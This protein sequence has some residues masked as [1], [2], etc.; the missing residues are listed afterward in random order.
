[1]ELQ[2][3]I[4]F[5]ENK[6]TVIY[7]ANLQGKTNVINAIRYAFLKEA[8]KGRRKKKYDEH[9]LP[10]TDEIIREGCASIDIVFEKNGIYYKLSRKFEKTGRHVEMKLFQICYASNRFE[11]KYFS[12]IIWQPIEGDPRDFLKTKLNV[13]LIDILF[14]PE[15]ASGFKRLYGEDENIEKAL[16]ELFKEISTAR[17][18][19]S[20]FIERIEKVETEASIMKM[21]I[22]D[23]YAN[24]IRRLVKLV[25]GIDNWSQY[26]SL[27]QY[28]PGKTSDKLNSLLNRVKR[29]VEGLETGEFE[30]VLSKAIEK[31]KLY[32]KLR[33]DL[34]K[35]KWIGDLICKFKE[36]EDDCQTLL[37]FYSKN[38]SVKLDEGEITPATFHKEDLN[39]EVTK[40]LQQFMQIRK[41]L[42]TLKEGLKKFEISP[43]E[44]DAQIEERKNILRVL[45]IKI[46]PRELFEGKLTKVEGKAYAVVPLDLIKRDPTFTKLSRNPIPEGAGLNEY[47]QTLNE[48]IKKLQKLKKLDEEIRTQF[49][50]FD[51]WRRNLPL[52]K[53]NKLQEEQKKIKKKITNFITTITTNASAFLEKAI[54]QPTAIEKEVIISFMRK[55]KGEVK[56][57]ADEYLAE[58]ND[59]LKP[60]GITIKHLKTKD[61]EAILKR[62]KSQKEAKFKALQECLSLLTNAEREWIAKDEEFL[63]YEKIP[64]IVKSLKTICQ[65]ILD[66]SIDEKALRKE[67]INVF[68]QIMDKLIQMKLIQAVPILKEDKLKATIKYKGYKITHPAGAEKV[69]Y[70]LA[71]LSSLAHYFNVP[72]LMDEVANNLDTKNLEAFFRLAKDL[73]KNLNIQYI[74]SVKE[75]KDFDLEG[76][77]RD[78]SNNLSIYK[79]EDKKLQHL[80][81]LLQQY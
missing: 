49:N 13:G 33:E 52:S 75:T 2:G 50:E 20:D 21:K 64:D 45:K 78:L 60:L 25:P 22:K 28:E 11:K 48:E 40:K 68:N 35:E 77:V 54:T 6:I 71:I 41:M 30:Q 43:E 72:I 34:G 58:I 26:K 3:E 19:A 66:K 62:I 57:K 59:K 67:I 23:C 37:D 12:D 53:L 14:A 29:I 55:L 42:Y 81:K 1:M 63:D 44:L 56:S 36:L 51:K 5:P 9:K 31:T 16:A 69:F 74:F 8:R 15:S 80:H 39:R 32:D 61:I 73:S 70:S 38:Q 18:L 10:M 24:L 65:Q 47:R 7:G 79:L 76:W 4:E 27:L 17:E 46:K